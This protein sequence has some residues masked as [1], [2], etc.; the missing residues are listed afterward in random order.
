MKHHNQAEYQ[1][2]KK[3][4]HLP[5]NR[6]RHK[7]NTATR[8]NSFFVFLQLSGHMPTLPH[9]I[10]LPTHFPMRE[11]CRLQSES[12]KKNTQPKHNQSYT[13]S[14]CSRKFPL[15][16]SFCSRVNIFVY[17]PLL[18]RAA[19]FFCMFRCPYPVF[20]YQHPQPSTPP[21]A[22]H[23]LH[24]LTKMKEIKKKKE[25][26]ADRYNFLQSSQFLFRFIDPSSHSDTP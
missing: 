20:L 7:P 9:L 13:H 14:H 11:T 16:F 25:T 8:R 19:F 26:T 12:T 15:P 3:R 22:F 24:T 17:Q 4:K 6:R 18:T 5:A 1:R 10:Q 2:K 21:D 23:Q